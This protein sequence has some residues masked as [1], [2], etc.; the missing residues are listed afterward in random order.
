MA[1][2]EGTIIEVKN[3]PKCFQSLFVCKYVKCVNGKFY[4]SNDKIH[5]TNHHL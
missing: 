5:W 2:P 4:Q 1:V 3:L